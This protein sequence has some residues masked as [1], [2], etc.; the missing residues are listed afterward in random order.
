MGEGVH[1]ILDKYLLVYVLGIKKSST[2][3][4]VLPLALGCLVA[5][6]HCNL[7]LDLWISSSRLSV[8]LRAAPNLFF[9]CK[10]KNDLFISRGRKQKYLISFIHYKL[11][12]GCKCWTEPLKMRYVADTLILSG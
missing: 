1:L 6:S 4:S 11:D 9:L 2:V 7:D 10:R 8:H 3:S 12:G 5:L